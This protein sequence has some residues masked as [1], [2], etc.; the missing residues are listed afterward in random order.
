MVMDRVKEDKVEK[1]RMASKSGKE[2][3]EAKMRES[4]TKT[5]EMLQACLETSVRKKQN[6]QHEEGV[7]VKLRSIRLELMM[8]TAKKKEKRCR[9][10]RMSIYELRPARKSGMSISVRTLTLEVG[11]RCV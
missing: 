3:L 11:A 5:K 7:N 6:G 10:L 1:K 9:H 8:R 2:K 4:K